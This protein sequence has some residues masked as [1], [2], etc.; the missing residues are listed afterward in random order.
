MGPGLDQFLLAAGIAEGI[1]SNLTRFLGC[2]ANRIGYAEAAGIDCWMKA[3]ADSP[4]RSTA[5]TFGAW[6][7]DYR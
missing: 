4:D 7:T 3:D 2:Y 1:Q 6:H 5:G